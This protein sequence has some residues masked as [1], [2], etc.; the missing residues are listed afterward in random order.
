MEAMRRELVWIER[1]DF[2]GWGCSLC[3]WVFKMAGSPIGD[4]IDKM[5]SQYEKQR[6]KEFAS[7]ACAEHPRIKNPKR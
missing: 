6:D 1:S 5:R 3:A 7:H 4:S 2:W